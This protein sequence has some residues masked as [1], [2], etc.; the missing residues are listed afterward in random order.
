MYY[1]EVTGVLFEA[2]PILLAARFSAFNLSTMFATPFLYYYVYRYKRVKELLV[3][4]TLLF[5]AKLWLTFS[6]FSVPAM[7]VMQCVDHTL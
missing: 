6:A 7:Y 2:R 3:Y 4:V 5:G 1:G